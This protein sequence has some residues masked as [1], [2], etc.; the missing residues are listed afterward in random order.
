M[1][2]TGIFFSFCFC[3]FS[4]DFASSILD[5]TICWNLLEITNC[6]HL[7]SCSLLGT[8][9]NW[10][11]HRFFG[12]IK[13]GLLKCWVNWFSLRMH[14]MVEKYAWF[15]FFFFNFYLARGY[16]IVNSKEQIPSPDIGHCIWLFIPNLLILIGL[17]SWLLLLPSYLVG[18]GLEIP[19]LPMLDSR[20]Y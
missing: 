11:K 9:L 6:E 3:L 5:I 18:F 15:C 4:S 17:S 12:V 7:V 8:S 16:V 14:I 20:V 13:I 2:S 10:L 1:W 19:S